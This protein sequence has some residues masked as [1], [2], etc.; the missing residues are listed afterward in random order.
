[1]TS[2]RRWLLVGLLA[3]A[4]QSG[5]AQNAAFAPV[6]HSTLA[7]VEAAA[8][9][10][11]VRLRLRRTEGSAPLAVSELQV[12]VA[13]QTV[14]A[15]QRPDG[16]WLAPWPRSGAA[17]GAALEVV[18]T[19]DGIREVLSGS[20][21]RVLEGKPAAGPRAG[22]G[23]SSSRKQLAWWILNIAIVLIAVV[24]ISRRMS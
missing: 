8:T 11:G 22:S 6:A 5:A 2:I 17:P 19:H 4:A 16:T 20:L 23:M 18:V 15:T 14:P 13:G 12:S 7:T 3:C 1:M 10:D 9:P 24:A 21:P